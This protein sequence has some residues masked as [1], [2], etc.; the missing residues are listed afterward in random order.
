MSKATGLKTPLRIA[1]AS[2]KG[3]TGKT[4]LS[5]ALALSASGPVSLLD[6]DVEE[7]NA[8]LFLAHEAE[9]A[10][11]CEHEVTVP[12][13]I[14]D[15]AKCSGCG[16]CAKICRFNAIII[17][18]KDVTIFPDLCH[19]CGGCALVCPEKAIRE[20]PKAVGLLR[21]WRNGDL[22]FLQGELDVGNAMSPPLIRAVKKQ[23]ASYDADP[24]STLSL[25][26]IDCPPGTSCP[27]VTAV[28]GSD[29]ALLVTEPTPFGLHD[30][31]LAV[32]TI[33]K[34][35]VP[36]GVVINRCD[37]GDDR[38]LKYCA[39]ERI[40]VLA[41]IPNDR[42]VAEAY[43]TGQALLAVD[44]TAPDA[45]SAAPTGAHGY[46]RLME[47]LLADIASAVHDGVRA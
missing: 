6:C 40:P 15:E 31:T 25:T 45:A 28:R 39:A 14:V 12:I 23:A 2:G 36:F 7:P 21:Q 26:I 5:V 44:A 24:D 4:T 17:I 38:V 1:V 11:L 16:E 30:L 32:A 47:K 18:K 13:P 10:A 42:R 9:E 19:S 22:R 46:R 20:E 29:F 35:S 34:M 41:Q 37:V 43:S 3:G 27:M 8:A 33:R